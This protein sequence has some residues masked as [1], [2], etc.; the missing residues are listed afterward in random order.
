MA[1]T[2][3]K[4][5]IFPFVALALLTMVVGLTPTT[6]ASRPELQ[7]ITERQP[8]LLQ[9]MLSQLRSTPAS[10]P[11]LYF[12]GF[13]GYGRQAVFKREVLA[14]RQIFDDRFGTNGRS[15]ALI[16]HPST[17]ND[18]PLASAS[19]LDGVLQHLGKLMNPDRDTLFLFLS[20]HG[21]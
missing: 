13:A 16:N 20:S 5:T 8:E 2:S 6:A 11:Q 19:N 17:A 18:I 10:R 14:V 9:R 1:H 3:K 4:I 12:V 15:V 21:V 7:A